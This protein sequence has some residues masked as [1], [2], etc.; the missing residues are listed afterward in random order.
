MKASEFMTKDV[1]TCNENQTVEEAATIMAEKGFSVLPIVDDSGAL[2]GVITESDFVSKSK[3]VPHAMVTLKHLFGK[4]F[5]SQD[6]E[7][8]YKES[9]SKKLSEIMTKNPKTVSPDATLDEVVTFLGEKDLKRVPV[10][11][12]GKV[13]GIITRKNII[14]AFTKVK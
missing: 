4:S 9:K 7:E 8:I 13:V 10:V 2:V 11:D 3:N 6:V 14:S 12:N 1:I 5:N